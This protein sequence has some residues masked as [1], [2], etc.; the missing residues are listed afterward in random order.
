MSSEA[1]SLGTT[2]FAHSEKMLAALL[3]SAAQGIITVDRAGRIVLVNR[4]AEEMFGYSRGE[5]LGARVEILIPEGRRSV[6]GRQRDEYFEK[7]RVRPMGN[8]HASSQS[9]VM[10]IITSATLTT[11]ITTRPARIMRFSP[12]VPKTRNYSQI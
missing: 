11:I 1:E 5:V 4:K 7:P 8:G 9:A 3:E 12:S 2:P 6:H 10:T